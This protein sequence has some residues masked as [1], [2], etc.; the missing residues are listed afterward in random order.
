MS[1]EYTYSMCRLNVSKSWGPDSRHLEGRDRERAVWS[2]IRGRHCETKKPGLFLLYA[3]I[4]SLPFPAPHTYVRLWDPFPTPVRKMIS[5]AHRTHRPG[6]AVLLFLFAIFLCFARLSRRS[7]P[8][9]ARQ[10]ARV[11]LI[12]SEMLRKY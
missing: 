7:V 3:P 5:S 6:S 9:I 11:V 10:T 2:V 4:T 12:Y 1:C 8:Y